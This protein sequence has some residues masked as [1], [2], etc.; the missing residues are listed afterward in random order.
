MAIEQCVR[1]KI[2]STPWE[3]RKELGGHVCFDCHID[4]LEVKKKRCTDVSVQ[5]D[6]KNL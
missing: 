1:C 6:S 5:I 4:L 2:L 3:Y